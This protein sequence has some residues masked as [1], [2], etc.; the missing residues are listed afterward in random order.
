MEGRCADPVQLANREAEWEI[1]FTPKKQLSFAIW[2]GVPGD[3]PAGARI[4]IPP[5]SSPQRELPERFSRANSG[6]SSVPAPRRPEGRWEFR[7]KPAPLAGESDALPPGRP[8]RKYSTP[9][10]IPES[11]CPPGPGPGRKRGWLVAV[12]ANPA[13]LI[14]AFVDPRVFPFSRELLVFV[15]SLGP[16]LLV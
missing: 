11:F 5:S 3:L 16:N 9:W 2:P 13:V 15:A 14:P 8:R 7:A 4:S 1:L 6:N 12:A 10:Q